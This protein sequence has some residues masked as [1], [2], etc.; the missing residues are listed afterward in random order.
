MRIT[1]SLT[2]RIFLA[3][4]LVAALSL[5]FALYV[6]NARATQ[7]AEADLV[8]GLDEAGTLVEE[9]RE[10][11]T[12]TVTRLARLVAD[13]PKLKAAVETGDPPTV[14]PLGEEYR[15][16]IGTDLLLVTGR[17][18][19]PLATAGPTPS[20]LTVPDGL[21]PGSDEELA[22]FASSP[23]GVLQV[24]SEPIL[25]AGTPPDVLGRLTVGFYLDDG[26]AERIKRLTGSEI[27][28]GSGNSVLASTLPPEWN[29]PLTGVMQSAG[30]ATVRIAGDDEVV[31]GVELHARGA[32]A[33]E[34]DPAVRGAPLALRVEAG[35]GDGEI[36]RAHV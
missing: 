6:V 9:N 16:Q 23:N 36:G 1:S 17:Q 21:T 10:E 22:T 7:E 24:V 28:L 4:T 33:G 30:P 13:L 35:A 3:W 11:L 29:A 5:G 8:R 15:G 2:N 18:G 14:Q 12:N 31:L 32:Q 19:Q 26:F 27:A 20:D 25:L 34:R